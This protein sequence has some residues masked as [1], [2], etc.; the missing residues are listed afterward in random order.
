MPEMFPLIPDTVPRQTGDSI[1]RVPAFDS[2]SN[3]FLL[4]DGALVERTGREAVQQWFDLML[5]QRIDKVPIYR[6]DGETKLGIDREMLGS[7]LPSGL[8]TAEIER[9]VRET[10]S[11]C[12]A[13]RAVRDFTVTR[14]GR[15]CHVEFTA[16]LYTNETLEVSADV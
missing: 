6:T 13:V 15:A 14:R 1:G 3:R 11:F 9:N 7:R 2:T 5:R 12:P 4:L 10:A 8:I 16:E